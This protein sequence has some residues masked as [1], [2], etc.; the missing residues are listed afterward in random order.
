MVFG[1]T[2][3]GKSVFFVILSCLVKVCKPVKMELGCVHSPQP[4]G[5]GTQCPTIAETSLRAANSVSFFQKNG[6]MRPGGATHC[7]SPC[8]HNSLCCLMK[9]TSPPSSDS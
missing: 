1:S 7:L 8:F 9:R 6:T 3:P 5:F 4:P 2:Q